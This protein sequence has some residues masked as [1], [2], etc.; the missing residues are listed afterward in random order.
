MAKVYNDKTVP[1]KAGRVVADSEASKVDE[2]KQASSPGG[3]EQ[4]SK[5]SDESTPQESNVIR[6]SACDLQSD[7]EVHLQD[8]KMTDADKKVSENGS[9]RGNEHKTND[10]EFFQHDPTGNILRRSERN[11]KN[12]QSSYG[13][14]GRRPFKYDDFEYG[15]NIGQKANVDMNPPGSVNGKNRRRK[16]SHMVA[17]PFQEGT[18]KRT[19]SAK[20]PS[21]HATLTSTENNGVVHNQ[22]RW[23]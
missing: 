8:V 10:A 5:I 21:S 7:E 19:L 17:A 23:T 6:V 18:M 4:E 20:T 9:Q 13:S 11:A 3:K 14:F 16:T 1:I 15:P 22:G 12:N 2:F